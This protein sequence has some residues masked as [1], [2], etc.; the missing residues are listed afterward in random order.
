MLRIIF[1]CSNVFSSDPR[2]IMKEIIT[3]YYWTWHMFI[4]LLLYVWFEHPGHTYGGFVPSFAEQGMTETKLLEKS[5]VL[6]TSSP[7]EVFVSLNGKL[8]HA[9]NE[10]TMLVV[11]PHSEKEGTKPPYVCPGCSNH[12]HGN[13]M[14]KRCNLVNK[15]VIFLT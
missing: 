10:N 8:V 5:H 11:I 3:L 2:V 9:T 15:R 13:N 14:I 12:T 7:C 4:L 1:W 6:I